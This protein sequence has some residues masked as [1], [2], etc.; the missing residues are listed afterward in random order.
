MTEP[1]VA[2]AR[3]GFAPHVKAQQSGKAS[4]E[5]FVA[6]IP[7]NPLISHDPDERIQGNPRKSNP[8]IGGFL[9]KTATAQENPNEPSA[10]RQPWIAGA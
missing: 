8:I 6:F 1:A 10:T 7:R 4:R 9:G 5:Y 2:Y 3:R